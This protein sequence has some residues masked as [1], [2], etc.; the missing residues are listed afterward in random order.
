[1]EEPTAAAEAADRADAVREAGGE[2]EEP[3]A[4]VRAAAQRDRFRVEA[5]FTIA[6]LAA[7]L[8]ITSLGGAN[9]TKNMINSNI[10]ASDTYAFYQ[11]KNIRQTDTRLALDRLELELPTLPPE[12]QAATRRKM[13]EYRQTIARYESE[14]ETG[15][16]K[17][18]LLQKANG[19]V[20]ERE[21]AQRQ[22]PYF[23]YAQALFQIAIVLGSLSI[24]LVA[25]PVLFLALA[26]GGVATLLMLD[27]YTL[28]VDL[29]LG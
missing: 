14:S 11:A 13:D 1:M 24:V 16:G 9:A 25:R 12:Q 3:E 17:K 23:D 26:L 8:A 5:G 21:R 4:R 19:Y 27:G 29:P 18:E 22:D 10:Q 7:L 20:A 28:L 2:D 15:E 6:V